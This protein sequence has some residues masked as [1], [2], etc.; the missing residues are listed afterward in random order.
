[1]YSNVKYNFY[2]SSL[3][4]AQHFIKSLQYTKYC[5]NN[6][7][8]PNHTPCHSLGLICLSIHLRGCGHACLKFW[9]SERSIVQSD[10]P[11]KETGPA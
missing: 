7:K 9:G 5:Q 3:N 10:N 4:P 8:A 11:I 1:M 2:N 6:V